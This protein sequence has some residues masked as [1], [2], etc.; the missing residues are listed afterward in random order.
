MESS[1]LRLNALKKNK[2]LLLLFFPSLLLANIEV[3]NTPIPGGI[4]VVDFQSNHS[5]P[6]VFYGKVPVYVQRIKD[7]HW[8]ALVGIPLFS[9]HTLWQGLFSLDLVWWLPYYWWLVK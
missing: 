8:Q 4:A 9:L 2:L 5:N 7:Q 3:K 1:T 6:S